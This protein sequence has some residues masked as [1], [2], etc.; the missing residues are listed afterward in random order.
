MTT[1]VPLDEKPATEVRWHRLLML[2]TIAMAVL[3]VVSVGGLLW[4]HRI[5]DGVPIWLKPFKF[6]VSFALYGYTLAWLL[7]MVSRGR[8]I[9]SATGSVIAISGFLEFALIVLQV[10]RGQA[11]HFNISTSFNAMVYNAMGALADIVFVATFVL[12]CLLAFKHTDDRARRWSLRFGLVTSLVGMGLA[13]LMLTNDSGTPA[14]VGGH[15]VG[16]ADGGRAMPITGWNLDGGDLRIPHFVGLHGLQALPLLAL[17]LTW[18]ARRYP[19]LRDEGV[20]VRLLV[21]GTVAYAGLIALVLWQA[22]RGQSIAHPDWQTL[23][24]FGLIVVWSV[25]GAGTVV[26]RAKTRY[27]LAGRQ[28]QRP[29]DGAVCPAAGVE[30]L[31]G[32]G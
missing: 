31:P 22:L 15:S 7:T 9:A 13:T 19:V 21:V 3:A 14:M 6:A 8:R 2:F 24:T 11:S 20:R 28:G 17:L 16:V 23:A 10:V 12:A 27:E 18:L 26:H 1:F 5:L 29:G 4:D 30:S 25:V 32:Q